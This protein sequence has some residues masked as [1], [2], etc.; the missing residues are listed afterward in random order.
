MPS[1]ITP[2][3][4]DQAVK[5]KHLL[6][7]TS[8]FIDYE[9]HKEDFISLLA[10]MKKLDCTLVTV[11][12]VAIEYIKGSK[13]KVDMRKRLAL[14]NSCIDS[15]LPVNT[16]VY[17]EQIQEQILNYGRRSASAAIT[18]LVLGVLAKNHQNDLLV[19]TKNSRDFPSHLFRLES[20]FLLQNKKSNTVQIYCIYK[21]QVENGRSEVVSADQIP[22]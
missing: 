6:F 8:F 3:T 4:L 21:Y 18:D 22:C 15:Y 14:I 10:R 12:Q 17:S 16:K 7:D 13:S 5:N 1:V 11:D 20:H 19:L 9:N 2:S